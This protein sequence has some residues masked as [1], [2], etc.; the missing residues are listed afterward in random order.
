MNQ[1]AYDLNKILD[2]CIAGRL[3]SDFGRRIYFPKGIIAQSAEAKKSAWAANATIG[4]AFHQGKPMILS[5]LSENLPYLSEAETVAYAP[6]AGIEEVRELWQKLLLEKNPSLRRECISLPVVV[7]GITAGISYIA[8]LFLNKGQRLI[9]NDPC[10]DNYN[11]IFEERREAVLCSVRFLNDTG[12]DL[13]AICAAINQEAK[14]GA[15]RLILNFPNNPAG[16]S[17]TRMEEDVLCDCLKDAAEKGADVLVICDD[18]YY[19]LVYEDTIAPESIFCRLSGL[20]ERI[21]AV[22]ADGPTKEDYVWGLRVALVTFG[23]KGMDGACFN[24][25]I[26]KLMG[27]I[28]SSVSCS[29][30][31]AQFLLLK[32]FAGEKTPAEKAHYR[33]ILKRRYQAVRRFVEEHNNHHCLKALPFNSGYFMS[34]AC[35][36]IKSEDL[37]RKLLAEHGIGTVALGGIYLR[38]AYA[39][40][41]EDLIAPLL[42]TIFQAAEELATQ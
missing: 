24:A 9:M 32:T 41:N 36:G 40:L 29:N 42:A 21:L 15:V 16:Y 20:H 18:A 38:I 2:D 4:M 10:W 34:F 14:T 3:L 11:L 19:G 12:L 13:D 5:A 27:V 31:P 22:K 6:T 25:L 28:R 1:L 7:P 35:N 39:A 8:D 17:P 37:R 23:S 30:T 33:A 26:S